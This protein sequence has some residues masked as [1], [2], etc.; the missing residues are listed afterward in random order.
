MDYVRS[1]INN[2]YYAEGA[3]GGYQEETTRRTRRQGS[4]DFEAPQ[5][6]FSFSNTP[7]ATTIVPDAATMLENSSSSSIIPLAHSTAEFSQQPLFQQYA[8]LPD[9]TEH[10]KPKRRPRQHPTQ[11]RNGDGASGG[12]GAGSGDDKSPTPPPS[13]PGIDDE[14]GDEI[15]FF[16]DF[17]AG[18]VAGCASVVVGHPFDT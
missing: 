15:T 16:H 17:V 1:T 18:G 3:N 5:E 10:P 11:P 9:F 6:L 4:E 8:F 14:S 7:L 2:R 13:Q 12:D